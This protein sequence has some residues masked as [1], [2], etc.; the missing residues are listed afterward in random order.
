MRESRFCSFVASRFRFAL[1]IIFSIAT[2]VAAIFYIFEMFQVVLIVN[3]VAY[4]RPSSVGNI[5]SDESCLFLCL[6]M[7][8]N[9]LLVDSFYFHKF[10]HFYRYCKTLH[11][12]SLNLFFLAC[13]V[14]SNSDIILVIFVYSSTSP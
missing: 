10:S 1:L 11:S 5:Y 4:T 8:Y 3:F 7:I 9:Q 2:I 12:L 13:S 6:R 14:R